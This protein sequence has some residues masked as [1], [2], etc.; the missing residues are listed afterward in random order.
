LFIAR[1]LGYGT[2][3]QIEEAIERSQQVGRMLSGL[4]IFLKTKTSAP[5]P[6]TT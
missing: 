6:P 3:E 5:A 4:S 2:A 1:R